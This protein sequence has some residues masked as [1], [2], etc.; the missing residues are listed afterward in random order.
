MGTL[1][2]MDYGQ[3]LRQAYS[4]ERLMSAYT[5]YAVE[6]GCHVEG[7]TIACDSNQS[8]LLEAKWDELT[9]AL[10]DAED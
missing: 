2:H 7:D 8:R 9:G 4:A 5:A 3:M 6:I 1:R 10:F